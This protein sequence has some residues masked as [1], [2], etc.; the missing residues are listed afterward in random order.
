MPIPEKSTWPKTADGTTDWELLFE[1]EETGLIAGTRACSSPKQLKQQTEAIIGAIFTRKRDQAIIA[2]VTAY[3]DKLIPENA[4]EERL[5]TMKS[6]V[7][8]MFRKVKD[9]RIRKAALYVVKKKRRDKREKRKKKPNRRANPFVEFS[10]NHKTATA[11]LILLLG[12][13]VPLGIYL[14]SP[15]AKVAEGNVKEHIA[16]IENHVFNHMPQDTWVLQSVKQ[17]KASQIAVSILITDPEHIDAIH[18]MRRISR[19][20]ILNQV[21]PDVG[22]G[23]KDILDMGWSVWIILNGPDELLTGGTCH[24]E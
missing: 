17:S 20:A 8:Q 9:D 18:A 22:S 23:I 11:I 6:G 14:G 10:H 3:L 16:W 12:A 2:K 7:E 24:Y 13:L 5:P 4:N 19:V 15:K 21:C 1:D